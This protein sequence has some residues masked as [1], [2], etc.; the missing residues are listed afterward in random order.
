MDRNHPKVEKV[1]GSPYDPIQ[2]QG[3][4]KFLFDLFL[5][6][7]LAPIFAQDDVLDDIEAGVSEGR[8]YKT[9]NEQA[10]EDL[11]GFVHVRKIPGG[12]PG[13]EMTIPNLDTRTKPTKPKP[14]KLQITLP[15]KLNF[16]DI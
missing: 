5:I 10:A 15:I 7:Y 1:N 14:Q 2:N 13:Q 3:G 16:L 9:I 6:I 4:P 8:V 11:L 12:D